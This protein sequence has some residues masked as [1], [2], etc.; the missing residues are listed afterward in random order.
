MPRLDLR[1]WLDRLRHLWLSS[2]QLRTVALTVVLST[3]AVTV[4]GGFISTS[5]RSNL[6]DSRREQVVA[7]ASRATVNAQAEFTNAAESADQQDFDLVSANVRDVIQ[8]STSSPSEAFAILRAPDQDGASPFQD[9]RVGE[10]DREVLVGAELQAAV[11]ASD[12]GA[13]YAQPVEIRSGDSTSPGLIAGSMLEVQGAGRYQL[14]L[15]FSLADVQATL[16]FV[17]QTI[18]LGGLAL[19]ALIALVAYVVVRL[20]V[21][22]VRIAAE[23][24]EKLA[25]GML[26]ERLPERGEDVLAVLAR[27]FNRMA[28]SLQQQIRQL[29]DLSHVQQRFVSDVSHEL[30]TPLTTI[31]LAGDVLYDQRETFPPTTAR[32]AE[33]LHTQTERFELLLAD[34]LEMSRYDAGA[35]ELESEP[36]SLVRLAED[37]IEQVRPLADERGSDLRLVAP[38]GYFEAEVDAR[39]IRRVLRNLLGNAIDHG[40]GRPIAV[41]VDSDEQ[42]VAIA[43]RDYGVGMTEEETRRVF[44]RFWRADPSRQRRTGGTGLGLAISLEDATVHGGRLEVWSAPGEGSCFLLTLPR[45]RGAEVHGSPLTLPPDDGSDFV[46]EVEP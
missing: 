17:Q 9:V 27:S 41:H 43:V 22:P 19:V 15:L 21:G 36:T 31:R 20:V 32:T 6:F 8:R 13:V 23:T 18:L 33:L 14:Y 5:V 3:I 34:L 30:R 40:E 42:A 37:A 39:R 44:D 16:G 29:A 10:F 7:S 11:L 2:L 35:V 28:D 25:A 1:A 4:I 12:G 38:G 26:E 45:H 24:S 46:Q